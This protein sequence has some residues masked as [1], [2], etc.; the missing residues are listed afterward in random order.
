VPPPRLRWKGLVDGASAIRGAA[1]RQPGRG[2]CGDSGGRRRVGRRCCQCGGPQTG[3]RGAAAALTFV[4]RAGEHADAPR[5]RLILLDL[6]LAETHGLDVLAQL[7]TED[8]LMTIPVVI[9]SPARHPADIERS[10][11][12]HANAYI[13]K[14]VDL[15]AFSRVISAIDACFLRFAEP[16]PEPQLHNHPEHPLLDPAKRD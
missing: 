10:Y 9:L 3:R 15:D 11:T 12:M 7:K 13:V 14:P 4:R 16:S 1:P 8:G 5:P 2:N 6:N